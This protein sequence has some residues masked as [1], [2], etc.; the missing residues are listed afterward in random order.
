M[1]RIFL[2]A[3]FSGGRRMPCGPSLLDQAKCQAFR[4]PGV[5]FRPGDEAVSGFGNGLPLAL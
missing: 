3:T 1:P 5:V 2:A 4:Q